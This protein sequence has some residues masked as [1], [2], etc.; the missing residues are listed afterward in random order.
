M[1]GRVIVKH[2][3]TYAMLLY[4]MGYVSNSPSERKKAC[5][6]S[7]RRSANSF[8]GV[9]MKLTK[10]IRGVFELMQNKSAEERV[11]RTPEKIMEIT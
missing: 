11:T 9:H 4:Y 5:S 8:E 7:S 2:C 6:P 3:K 10:K 1:S